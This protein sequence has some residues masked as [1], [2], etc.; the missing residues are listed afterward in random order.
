MIWQR[1]VQ[2]IGTTTADGNG[3]SAFHVGP[4]QHHAFYRAVYPC[5]PLVGSLSS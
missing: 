4:K 1:L 3:G 2:M 5:P